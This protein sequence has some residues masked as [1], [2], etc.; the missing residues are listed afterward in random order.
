VPDPPP[1][2]ATERFRETLRGSIRVFAA[3]ALAV[4][5][6]IAIV[7]F[8]AR[9]LGADGYGEFTVAAAFVAW[10]EWSLASALSRASVTFVAQAPDRRAAGAA[11]VRTYLVASLGAALLVWIAAPRVAVALR[12]PALAA[13]LRLFVLDLP[14]FALA[15]AHRAILI[16]VGAF[17][18]RAI[19]AAGRWIARMAGV[20]VLVG[21]GFGIPGAIVG[22]LAASVVELAVARRYVRPPLVGRPLAPAGMLLRA[23]LPL[24]LLDLGMRAFDKVDL[25]CLMALTGSSTLAGFY[26]AAQN[27]SLAPGMFALSFSPL[28]LSTLTRTVRSDGEAVARPVAVEALRVVVGLVPFAALA[29]GA[30]GEITVLLLGESFLPAASLF[31]VLVF[32]ALGLVWLSV[33]AAVLTAAGKPW[34]AVAIAG[35]LV[36]LAVAGHLVLI[37]RYGALGAAAVSTGLALLGGIVALGAVQRI[38]RIVPPRAAVLRAAALAGG[39]WVL[40]SVWSTPGGLLAVKLAAISVA[41][42]ALSPQYG[43]AMR[44]RRP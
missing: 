30:S 33:G 7:G 25:F 5:T 6:G 34:W 23:G 19:L 11:V 38:W 3:E 1:P 40:A 43:P 20:L 41:I 27:L 35:P 8:L 22:T 18:A 9:R 10:V 17:T 42:V 36:A 15:Q 44:S 28:L 37:P 24:A 31:A 39:A 32:G 26:G 13:D 21:L 16:G 2:S 4:P 29:A 14:L 12:Q